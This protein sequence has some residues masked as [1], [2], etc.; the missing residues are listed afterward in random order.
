MADQ[1]YLSSKRDANVSHVA[2]QLHHAIHS[3]LLVSMVVVSQVESRL[4]GLL[5]WR[6]WL[7]RRGVCLLEMA[8]DDREHRAVVARQR[9]VG[10]GLL[11]RVLHV[12]K[13]TRLT[14]SQQANLATS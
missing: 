8:A 6:L 10:E 12:Y 5:L 14:Q 11:E 3:F 1:L 2:H 9:M 13:P 4:V 7:Q